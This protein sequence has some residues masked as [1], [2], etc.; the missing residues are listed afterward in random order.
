MVV[1]EARKKQLVNSTDLRQNTL[2]RKLHRAYRTCSNKHKAFINIQ[3]LTF[4]RSPCVYS[5]CDCV[6]RRSQLERLEAFEQGLAYCHDAQAL[7][8]RMI[9]A[10]YYNGR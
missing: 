1:K 6:C 2:G 9:I 7:H 8:L 3:F 5:A 10:E 4:C